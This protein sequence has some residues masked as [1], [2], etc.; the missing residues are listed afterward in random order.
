MQRRKPS[1]ISDEEGIT[2][3]QEPKRLPGGLRALGLQVQRGTFT[4]EG[5]G[6]V[7]VGE[8]RV[9]TKQKA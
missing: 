8:G 2:G 3:K 9:V 4:P 5:G 6:K 7:T 1:S